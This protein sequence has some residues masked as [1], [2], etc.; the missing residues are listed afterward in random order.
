MTRI[1]LALIAVGYLG[2]AIFYS[3]LLAS[4]VAAQFVC[5]VCPNIDSIGSPIG[6]FVRRTISLG[7]L[8]ALIFATAGWAIITIVVRFKKSLLAKSSRAGGASAIN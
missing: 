7:T 1:I 6:K 5:P 3:D 2:A 4:H 8:N